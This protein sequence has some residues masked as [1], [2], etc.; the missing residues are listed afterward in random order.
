MLLVLARNLTWVPCLKSFQVSGDWCL[1]SLLLQLRECTSPLI[2]ERVTSL[3]IN[4]IGVISVAH[5]SG[6]PIYFISQHF[7]SALQN[8]YVKELLLIKEKTWFLFWIFWFGLTG[9]KGNLI[10]KILG[11]V[12]LWTNREKNEHKRLLCSALSNIRFKL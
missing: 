7:P 4:N 8:C 9:S 10:E 2:W 12:N 1:N 3:N 5:I 6:I 11:D